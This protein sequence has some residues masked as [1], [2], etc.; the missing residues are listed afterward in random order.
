MT[1]PSTQLCSNC[2][3]RKTGSDKLKLSNRTYKCDKCGLVIDR[4]LNSAYNLKNYGMV[5]AK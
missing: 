3:N 1:F 5:N 2:G 4:D